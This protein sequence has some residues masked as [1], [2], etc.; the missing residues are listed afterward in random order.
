MSK[1]FTRRAAADRR[2]Q[3]TESVSTIRGTFTAGES[4]TRLTSQ[5]VGKAAI[6]LVRDML[7]SYILPNRPDLGYSGL[8][9]VRLI[10]NNK[11]AEG[12]ITIHAEFR[13]RTGINVGIDIPVEVREGQLMEPS[14]VVVDGSPR[15]VAQSTF[16]AIVANNTF[17]E[18]ARIRSIY[19]A[20]HTSAQNKLELENR[21]VQTRVNNG[22]F[23]IPA[24]R[25]ALRNIL[26]GKSAQY[27]EHDYK[28][29]DPARNV[30][31]ENFL[32]PAEREQ[33]LMSGDTTSLSEEVE[34]KNRGGGVDSY[35]SGSK[36][37][38]VR[39]RAG[40]GTSYVVEFDDGYQAIIESG[41]LKK[42][43]AEA[44]PAEPIRQCL[45]CK[46]DIFSP[47]GPG[48]SAP[49]WQGHFCSEGC[50]KRYI[51]K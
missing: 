25:T 3:R 49:S 50:K 7:G 20:P 40:D 9:S 4:K 46:K 19:S 10:Q 47:H 21:R 24:N 11:I 27:V 51:A 35:P 16:D 22:L 5:N 6:D 33:G 42:A 31:P 13:T 12:V 41:L 28:T 43:Q 29:F 23:S 17:K 38:I 39:D 1:Y 45:N 36:V 14:V 44:T 34:V 37:T 15:I 26:A 18:D 2:A 32:N 30:D 8:R 48:S